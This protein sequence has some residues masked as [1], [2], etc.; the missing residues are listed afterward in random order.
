MTTR[1]VFLAAAAL[2]AF[3][4]AL[5]VLAQQQA[6]RNRV[7]MQVSDNDPGKWNLALNNATNIQ[8]ELGMDDVDVEIVVYGPGIGMLKAGSPVAPRISSALTNGVKVVACENTMAGMHL[9]KSDMLPD[10]GYVPA[11]VVELMKKQQQG[12]AYVRP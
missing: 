8:K 6:N 5:P 1:R 10:I 2:P 12:W 3:L 4:L 11:G 9:Q 7:V